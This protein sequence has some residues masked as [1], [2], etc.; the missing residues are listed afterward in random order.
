MPNSSRFRRAFLVPCALALGLSSSVAVAADG[1]RAEVLAE[2]IRDFE[3]ADFRPARDALTDLMDA[4]DLASAQREEALIYLAATEHALGDLEATRGHLR[5]LYRD[6]P[7]AR[8]DP[9]IFLPELVSFSEDLRI[10]VERE[11]AL[12]Q[13]VVRAAPEPSPLALSLLP[14][15]TGQFANQ[16]VP[17]GIAFLAGEALLFGAS[18]LLYAQFSGNKV[19]D[20]GPLQGGQFRDPGAARALQLG[21]FATFWAGMAL[22]VGGVIDALA[23]R[24][25]VTPSTLSQQ[26][27]PFPTVAER[28]P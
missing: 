21:Y 6:F 27:V 4:P 3:S 7:A 12:F 11:R 8:L 1:A 13:P 22:N 18:A 26:P 25:P 15:G 28:R 17:K 14:F 2:A 9:G 16:Q 24:K 5:R 19:V 20:Y 23:H 10:E